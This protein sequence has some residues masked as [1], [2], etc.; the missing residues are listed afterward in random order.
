MKLVKKKTCDVKMSKR[1]QNV[2]KMS[3]VKKSNTDYGGGSH[4]LMS[5][6]TSKLQHQF[7]DTI[8]SIG[9]R[10]WK[11]DEMVVLYLCITSVKKSIEF[12]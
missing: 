3:N 5:I 8:I 4:I 11:Q 10:D 9:R 7:P 1:C 12:L 6:L 2:K